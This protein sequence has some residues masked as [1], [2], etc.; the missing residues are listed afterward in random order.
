MP[1]WPSGIVATTIL[2]AEKA[3]AFEE[4]IEAGTTFD[5][6]APE[7]R[8]GGF[9]SQAILATEYLRAQRIRARICKEYDAWLSPYDAVLTA[10]RSG[11][12]GKMSTGGLGKPFDA[13]SL[14]LEGNLCGTPA[15]TLP[16]GPRRRRDADVA[17][18]RRRGLCRE[19]RPVAGRGLPVG[20]GL[21]SIAPQ[22]RMNW[23]DPLRF[24]DMPLPCPLR[25]LS[26]SRSR[27]GRCSTRPRCPPRGADAEALAARLR[28]SF[29]EG[30]DLTLGKAGP[31]R[32]QRRRRLRRSRHRGRRPSGSRGMVDHSRGL[33]LIKVGE[34]GLWVRVE[35]IPTDTKFAFA[36][37]VDG[38]KVGGRVV[39][40]PAWSYP[41]ESKETARGQVWQGRPLE[42]PRRGLQ[43]RPDRLDL[44]SRRL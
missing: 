14:L 11:T 23:D 36:Y 8:T 38:K 19:H 35:R 1:S 40:M 33:D 29:P 16:D 15:L 43:E 22:G 34:T 10:G 26:P 31:A 25:R 24:D 27:P 17:P 18:D 32:R 6:T 9:A 2:G 42:L 44:C 21:A 39:E 20:H 3:S 13:K 7:D 30:T 37:E 4:M 12:A 41:P 28:A 5:L